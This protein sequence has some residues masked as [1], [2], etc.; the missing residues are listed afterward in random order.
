MGFLQIRDDRREEQPGH[1]YGL[2]C[3]EQKLPSCGSTR[4]FV[5]VTDEL[6]E[7]ACWSIDIQL[8]AYLFIMQIIEE[9]RITGAC[10]GRYLAQAAKDVVLQC[11]AHLVKVHHRDR[12]AVIVT[13]FQ[14]GRNRRKVNIESMVAE[15]PGS[16]IA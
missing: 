2:P 7:D 4:A 9:N 12:E 6:A 14:I 15:P 3:L 16:E 5:A 10:R 11:L 8:P 13:Q 1:R